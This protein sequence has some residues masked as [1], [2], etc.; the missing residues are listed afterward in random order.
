[1]LPLQSSPRPPI[2]AKSPPNAT[3]LPLSSSAS[4]KALFTTALPAPVWLPA[5]NRPR[6]VLNQQVPLTDGAVFHRFALDG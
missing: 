1:M 4:A 5:G 6:I 3:L 2:R